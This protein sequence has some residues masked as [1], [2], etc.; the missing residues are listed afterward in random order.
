MMPKL[1]KSITLMEVLI[2]ILILG[3][4]LT[5]LLS[6]VARNFFNVDQ[7]TMR[8]QATY[9]AKEGIEMVLNI[10]DTNKEKGMVRNCVDYD[11]NY[12]CKDTF[13]T[14]TYKVG[15]E[16]SSSQYDINPTSQN[17]EDNLLY[18]HTGSESKFYFNHD[19]TGEETFFA[20]YLEFDEMNLKDGQ[21]SD[22]IFK[23]ESVVEYN[24]GGNK[25]EVS[26]ETFI[27]NTR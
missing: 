20:R 26:L 24:K 19:D 1:K 4:I 23:V 10:V 21:Q 18:Y 17:F 12:E 25:N 6:L 22:D 16:I 9:F 13:L 14:G 2:V 5:S 7:V 3:F 8:S 15:L 27:S 11:S